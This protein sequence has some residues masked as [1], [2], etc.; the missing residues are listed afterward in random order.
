M[1]PSEL[2]IKRPVTTLLLMLGIIV[3]GVM[4]YRQ[5]PVSDLP[6]VDFPSIQVGAPRTSGRQPGRRDCRLGRATA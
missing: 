3:F 6:T 2:F 4:A 5:L 1:N